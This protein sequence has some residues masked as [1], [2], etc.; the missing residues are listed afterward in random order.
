MHTDTDVSERAS[1]LKR[2]LLETLFVPRAADEGPNLTGMILYSL[3]STWFSL[4]VG[5]VHCHDARFYE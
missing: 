5:L 2:K 1:A 4:R 3:F